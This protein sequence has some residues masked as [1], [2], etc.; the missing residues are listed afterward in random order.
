MAYALGRLSMSNVPRH[1]PHRP[2]RH[3]LFIQSSPSQPSITI[4]SL[5]IYKTKPCCPGFPFSAHNATIFL[6]QGLPQFIE[7]RL[8]SPAVPEQVHLMFQG[9]FVGTTC[10]VTGTANGAARGDEVGA[11]GECRPVN[12][13]LGQQ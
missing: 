12:G 9:G 3:N 5:D 10:R 4:R 7:I 11:P 8:G 2:P 1:R 6:S 13:A